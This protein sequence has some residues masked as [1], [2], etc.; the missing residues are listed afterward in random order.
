ME[1]VHIDEKHHF[2]LSGLFLL[3]FDFHCP[4]NELSWSHD[5][6]TVEI[7]VEQEQRQRWQQLWLEL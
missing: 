4:L 3:T 5:E 6:K 1:E 2:L 7:V